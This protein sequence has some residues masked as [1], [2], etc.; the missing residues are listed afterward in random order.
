[1]KLLNTET[2]VMDKNGNLKTLETCGGGSGGSGIKIFTTETEPRQIA[3]STSAY[4]ID[5]MEVADIPDLSEI[6]LIN[7]RADYPGFFCTGRLNADGN[8]ILL[9]YMNH[10][11]AREDAIFK[12]TILYK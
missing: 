1:M 9:T 6:I 12:I 5:V 7:V 4:S 3:S 10:G 11:N 8:K 2:P